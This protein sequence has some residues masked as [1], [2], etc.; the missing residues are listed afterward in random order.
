MF[1]ILSIVHLLG[2]GQVLKFTYC[3]SSY[4][5]GVYERRTSSK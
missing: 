4:K 3:V 1:C 5:E 2:G